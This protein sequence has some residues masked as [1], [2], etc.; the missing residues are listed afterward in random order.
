MNCETGMNIQV[1]SSDTSEMNLDMT[2]W[3]HQE[4][5]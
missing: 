3:T 2:D 1:A 4:F 5:W